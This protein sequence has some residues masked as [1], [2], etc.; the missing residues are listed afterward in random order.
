MTFWKTEYLIAQ[1]RTGIWRKVIR[2]KTCP[3]GDLQAQWAKQ[4]FFIFTRS[5]SAWLAQ[6]SP[7]KKVYRFLTFN[8][9]NFIMLTLQYVVLP[10]KTWK[11]RS[12]KLQ[13]FF[14]VLLTC[15]KPAQILDVFLE[16]S[17]TSGLLYNDFALK[18][19]K[20]WRHSY[21]LE[22]E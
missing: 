20:Y 17:P 7:L 11:T 14:S 4:R 3:Q 9:C 1:L 16:K 19:I 18:N 6:N 10:L 13:I 22:S 5:Y 8:L 21:R 2:L 15:Q 12:Q